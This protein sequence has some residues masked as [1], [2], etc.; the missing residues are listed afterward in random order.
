MPNGN[1]LRG[2]EIYTS[3]I[4]DDPFSCVTCHALPTGMGPDRVLRISP[5]GFDPIPLGPNQE[6]HHAVV[7]VDGSTQRHFKVPQLRNMYKKTGFDLESLE[8]T[9]D[10]ATSTMAPWTLWCGS[11]PSRCL[12]WEPHKGSPMCWP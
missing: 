4:T 11:L 7:S 2:L 3:E 8:N 12:I 9:L 10:S 1:A 6:R 5:P